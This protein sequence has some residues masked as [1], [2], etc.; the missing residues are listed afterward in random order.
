M[1]NGEEREELE[2]VLGVLEEVSLRERE[3]EREGEI[4]IPPHCGRRKEVR[5][6]MLP[7]D[8]KIVK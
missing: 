1:E 8:E 2:R 4:T 6:S 5:G 3:R 7:E